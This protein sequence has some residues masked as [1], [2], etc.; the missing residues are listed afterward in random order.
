MVLCTTGLSTG[1]LYLR[2]IGELTLS[3]KP[4]KMVDW[5][6]FSLIYEG[7]GSYSLGGVLSFVV[8]WN[9]GETCLSLV[10]A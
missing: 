10:R 2:S 7:E 8:D 5:E 4:V 3:S 9:E 1:V 6:G